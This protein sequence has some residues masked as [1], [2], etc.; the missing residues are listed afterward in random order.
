[1]ISRLA[2]QGEASRLVSAENAVV[3]LIVTALVA[4]VCSGPLLPEVVRGVRSV[5]LVVRCGKVG[6][7]S[8]GE[9]LA[10]MGFGFV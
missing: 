9:H 7:A 8:L 4:G 10:G 5:V 1:M 2:M 3:V 6:L